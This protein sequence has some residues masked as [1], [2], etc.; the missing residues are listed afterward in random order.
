VCVWTALL[1]F[2]LAI[3]NAG[4]IIN[5]FTRIAGELFGMLITVLFLQEAIKVSLWHI[6]LAI[7][8]QIKHDL[9]YDMGK[10]LWYKLLQVQGIVSEFNVPKEGDPTSEKY[11]FDWLYAN[12]LLG[13]IFTFGLLYTSLKSRKARSWLYGTGLLNEFQVIWAIAWL[14]WGIWHCLFIE[15]GGLEVSLLIMGCLSWWWCGQHYHS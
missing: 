15:Q 14:Q 13:V 8:Y 7:N 11:N 6:S 10:G 2:L 9:A 12:G 5:R 4:N 3:F 1:L